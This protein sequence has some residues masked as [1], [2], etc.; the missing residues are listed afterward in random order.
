VQVPLG[1]RGAVDARFQILREAGR[2][3]DRPGVGARRH[4]GAPQPGVAR[5]LQVAHRTRIRLEVSG[6]EP[7]EKD[8]VLA[9]AQAVHGERGRRIVGR[10][11]GK[12]YAAGAEEVADTVF[13]RFPVD[14]LVVVTDRVEGALSPL[15]QERVEHL[16]PGFVMN[17]RRRR[18]DAIKIEQARDHVVR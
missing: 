11:L 2:L 3:D 12:A 6:A 15:R 13:A 10:A 8:R 4:D 1:D 18:E 14:V 7:V 9:V 17:L 16:R 5:G